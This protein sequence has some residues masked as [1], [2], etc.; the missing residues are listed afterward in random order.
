ML[1]LTQFMGFLSERKR[2][3]SVLLF[4][5]L[6][7]AP[8]SAQAQI[9]VLFLGGGGST[10]T[11]YADSLSRYFMPVIR[12]NGMTVEYKTN[13]SI[14]NAYSLKRYDVMFIYNSKKGSTGTGGDNS[15]NLTTRSE[16]HT[17]ELQSQ[18]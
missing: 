2:T 16:E 14:L 3:A 13:E 1:K 10:A 4:G 9:R 6:I 5:S 18:R 17:S 15:P 11:H 8:L 7:V 12:S